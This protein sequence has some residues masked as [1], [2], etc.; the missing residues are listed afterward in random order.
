[1]LAGLWQ[2]DCRAGGESGRR[3]GRDLQ[4]PDAG[5]KGLGLLLRPTPR[6]AD[7]PGLRLRPADHGGDET[8][9]VPRRFAKAVPQGAGTAEAVHRPLRHHSGHSRQ[10]RRRGPKGRRRQGPLRHVVLWGSGPYPE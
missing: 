9:G 2:R 4:Q 8:R 1:M 6:R 5:I 10:D 7:Q 3:S